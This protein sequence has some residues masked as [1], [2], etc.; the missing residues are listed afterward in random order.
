MGVLQ[1]YLMDLVR[2]QPMSFEEIL[3]VAYSPSRP[4]RKSE[5]RSLRRAL[6][7]LVGDNRAGGLIK[8]GNGG[9][10]DPYRYVFNPIWVGTKDAYEK[11]LAQ[12]ESDTERRKALPKLKRGVIDLP[13]Q[14]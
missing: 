11:L 13:D 12:I 9:P 14:S 6:Q 8:V 1:R 3:G 2:D 5:V 4:P 10:G 7:R